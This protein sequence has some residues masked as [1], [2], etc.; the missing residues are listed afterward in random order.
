MAADSVILW[1]TEQYVGSPPQLQVSLHLR[2]VGTNEDRI[3]VTGNSGFHSYGVA[4]D[5]LVWS[6]L[7]PVADPEVHFY[8]VSRQTTRTLPSAPPCM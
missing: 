3:V 7:P 5:T 4:G 1:S 2:R 6:F 8:S